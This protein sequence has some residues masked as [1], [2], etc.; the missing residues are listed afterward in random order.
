MATTDTL[1]EKVDFRLEWAGFDFRL[2]GRRLISINLSD[3]AAMGAEPRHA[4]LALALGRDTAVAD[5]QRL[6][7][8][9]TQQAHR[10]GCRIAGGDLS[11]TVGPLTFTATVVGTVR[12]PGRL[13]RRRGARPGWQL[14]V[15]GTLGG[16]AAGL[17]L[18]EAGSR[19]KTAPER[20]WVRAQLDPA[21]QL[22][23]GQTLVDAGVRVGGDISDGLFREVERIT[24]LDGFGA[25]IRVDRLPLASGLRPD[26]WPLAVRDSEDFQLICAAPSST[27]ERASQALA[28]HHVRL[29]T[30]GVVERD[31]GV[32]LLDGDRQVTLER[33]GYEHFR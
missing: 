20:T 21:P 17:Q 32:R 8:G 10:Y 6:Y 18:L 23:A 29:T 28:R 13:L 16:A 9:I 30:V 31:P 14:A 19:P 25:A 27:I 2:L 15:T 33:A 12:S 11:A 24:E 22:T 5:V 7:Q 4:L 1:V 26:D 3:L